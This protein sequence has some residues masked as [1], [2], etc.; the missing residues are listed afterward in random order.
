MGP[1]VLAVTAA[2]WSIDPVCNCKQGQYVFD[3][4]KVDFHAV[5]HFRKRIEYPDPGEYSFVHQGEEQ[6]VRDFEDWAENRGKAI[7]QGDED[8]LRGSPNKDELTCRKTAKDE[9]Q[10]DLYNGILPAIQKSY[11]RYDASGRH[12]WPGGG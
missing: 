5:V 9:L 11:D 3:E 4:Y 8:G 12:S 6:H 10:R 7:A 1:P 2:T